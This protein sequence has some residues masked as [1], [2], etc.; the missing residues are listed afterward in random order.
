MN[1]AAILQVVGAC[2]IVL[3]AAI[4]SPM[5]AV[6]LAGVFALSFGIWEEVSQ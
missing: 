4:V 1:L 6:L 5:V 2:L 3:A